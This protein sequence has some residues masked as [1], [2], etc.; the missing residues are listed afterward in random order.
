MSRYVFPLCL[1]I[2]LS[3]NINAHELQV[4]IDAIC[5]GDYQTAASI[6]RPLAEAENS[7]AQTKL[8][9]MY[10]KGL[11]VPIN[12][13]EAINWNR[14]AALQGDTEAQRFLANVNEGGL[15]IP[16][17]ITEGIKLYILA[18]QGGDSPAQDRIGSLFR[19]LGKSSRDYL[20]ESLRWYRSAA[21]NG[22]GG[23]QLTLG[24]MYYSG[25]F[26]GI[27]VQQDY[28]EAAQWYRFSAER[29]FGDAARK[30]GNM[31]LNGE[32]VKQDDISA[33]VWLSLAQEGLP[34]IADD[35]LGSLTNR[36]KTKQIKLGKEL[37][38][39][40]KADIILHREKSCKGM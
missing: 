33:Y 27:E 1:S 18:A 28:E 7:R 25:E 26:E 30:L 2:V 31:Y 37:K 40:I 13:L 6:L 16:R 17:N 22:D 19:E 10:F 3:T 15:G 38:N 21:E 14:R 39:S 4:G 32:G 5:S 29:G 34:D 9:L 24:D 11:G 20:D 12:Y 8:G 36:M 23:A 35:N